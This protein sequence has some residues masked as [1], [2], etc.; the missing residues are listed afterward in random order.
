MR[1]LPL[2]TASLLATLATAKNIPASSSLEA[3]P[4]N[5][6]HLLNKRTAE[7]TFNFIADGIDVVKTD[8]RYASAQLLHIRF[9]ADDSLN[10]VTPLVGRSASDFKTIYLYFLWGQ[11]ILLIQSK[12]RTSR[13]PNLHLLNNGWGRWQSVPQEIP[14]YDNYFGGYAPLDVNDYLTSEFDLDAAFQVVEASSS[15][16]SI[17]KMVGWEDVTVVKRK[18]T[19]AGLER[20]EMAYKFEKE[21]RRIWDVGVSSRE[22]APSRR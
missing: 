9:S 8:S 6:D 18:V 2:L 10:R 21:G 16:P 13:D 7:D 5:N 19:T 17:Q 1:L 15:V 3:F 12:W 4:P 20:G 11:K 14:Y 22:I